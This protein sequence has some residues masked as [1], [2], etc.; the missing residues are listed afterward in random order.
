MNKVK[1]IDLPNQ[2]KCTRIERYNIKNKNQY[3][4]V[5]QI[6]KNIDKKNFQLNLMDIDK[7][8]YD[9]LYVM[10]DDINNKIC[11]FM[12]TSYIYDFNNE[13]DGITLNILSSRSFKDSKY[14]KERIGTYLINELIEEAKRDKRIDFITN[15]KDSLTTQDADMNDVPFFNLDFLVQRYGGFTQE[16][17][18]NNQ[19]FKELESLEKE[20][21]S[22]EDA[23][24]IIAGESKNKFK[25]EE[26]G[27]DELG[28]DI[29]SDDLDLD[30]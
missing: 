5:L 27:E 21:Y 15:V 25:K 8:E 23:E 4:Q 22:K 18:K 20:G 1:I 7:G 28:D 24:K 13:I 29:G 26:S 19:R 12:L 11:G 16:D 10:K 14:T 30:I 9:F 2:E 3:K 6:F 17:L